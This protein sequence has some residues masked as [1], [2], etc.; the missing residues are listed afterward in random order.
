MFIGVAK[1]GAREINDSETNIA[2]YTAQ[3]VENFSGSETCG[4]A[5]AMASN[6]VAGGSLSESVATIAQVGVS[7]AG[8]FSG[9]P[10]A[11]AASGASL[12]GTA[13]S[14]F[15]ATRE[16]I[17]AGDEMYDLFSLVNHKRDMANSVANFSANFPADS[18]FHF[19]DYFY[20]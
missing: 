6:Y 2:A 19:T 3:Q 20:F 1:T 12:L 8:M 9:N 15:Q 10:L 14:V 7:L 13:A 11:M 18:C 16:L 5:F 4:M 17:Q